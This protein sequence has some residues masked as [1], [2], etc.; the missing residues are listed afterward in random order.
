MRALAVI[1]AFA[2]SLPPLSAQSSWCRYKPGSIGQ[3]IAVNRGGI[4]DSLREDQKNWI[5][6][7]QFAGLRAS[8]RY[9]GTTRRLSGNDSTFLDAYFFRVAPDTAFRALFH[10][11]QAFVDGR[12][13]LW[14]AV[15]DSLIPE[16][17][18]EARTGDSVTLF[19]SWLG[20]VQQGP[21]VQ[22]MFVVNEFGTSKSQAQ[23]NDA[24]TECA[25]E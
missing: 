10:Q 20:G 9:V 22:W 21:H 12:D 13:T 14:L 15:Q 23:W 17:A 16:M 25:K 18:E 6:N 7:N 19:T 11:E 8:V 4:N 3:L 1:A 24:L 5:I 2:A